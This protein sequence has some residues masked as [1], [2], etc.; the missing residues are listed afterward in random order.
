MEG[1]EG[2]GEASS[3][4]AAAIR[5]L[6]AMIKRHPIPMLP[7]LPRAVE[8]SDTKRRVGG[9]RNRSEEMIAGGEED[10]ETNEGGRAR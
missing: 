9:R 4:S 7:A 10:G 6:V 1:R 5:V 8:V 2:G 3:P